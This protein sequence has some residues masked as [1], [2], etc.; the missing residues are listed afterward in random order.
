MDAQTITWG[1]YV[2]S[3]A[4]FWF[5]VLGTLLIGYLLHTTGR[6]LHKTF[7]AV[8]LVGM[9]GLLYQS[10]Q[11]LWIVMTGKLPAYTA[12]PFWALK[13]IGM[14]LFAAMVWR[15]TRKGHR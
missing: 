7:K 2:F 3:G 8:V 1:D 11:C 13:D 4:L 14:V 9:G 15:V 5:D 10:M 12:Y 6:S